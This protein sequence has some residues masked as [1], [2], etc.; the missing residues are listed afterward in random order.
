MH[1]RQRHTR[2]WE[3]EGRMLLSVAE[4]NGADGC[5]CRGGLGEWAARQKVAND[6]A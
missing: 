3:G 2:A 1:G 6:M 4:T 5:A